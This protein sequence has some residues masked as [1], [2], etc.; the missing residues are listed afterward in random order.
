MMYFWA[1]MCHFR[2]VQIIKITL[3]YFSITI[4]HDYCR[5]TA[6]VIEV[7]LLP[8]HLKGSHDYTVPGHH[9]TA[10]VKLAE[11]DRSDLIQENN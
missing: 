7:I 1:I 11:M 3:R 2:V 4:F 6:A 9:S 8:G 5:S 10:A